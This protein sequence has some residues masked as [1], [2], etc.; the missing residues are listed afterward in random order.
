MLQFL[1]MSFKTV[2]WGE[3]RSRFKIILETKQEQ[4]SQLSFTFPNR[5]NIR[6][7]KEDNA[8]I[9]RKKHLTTHSL[10]KCFKNEDSNKS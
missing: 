7:I 10:F 1:K 9:G 4:M 2:A 6:Q 5:Q 3:I 8:V